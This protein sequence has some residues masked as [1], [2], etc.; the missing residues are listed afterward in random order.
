MKIKILGVLFLLLVSTMVVPAI[1]INVKETTQM[2][3][4]E[5]ILYGNN[6]NITNLPIL[7]NW[8]LDQEQTD[9]CGHGIILATPWLY[10]QSFTPTEDKIT[11]VRL[12]IFKYGNP[13]EPVQ[14]TVSIRD[15]LTSSD[16]TS[17]TIDTSVVTIG[18]KAIWVLFDFKDISVIPGSKYFIVCSGNAGDDTNA[19]CWFYE[20]GVPP[21]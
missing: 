10:A 17:K 5:T 19:Y 9:N 18:S 13:P 14:I 8:G 2:K 1:N 20:I 3:V 6:K 12:F 16:L 15:N 7:L 11:A 4:F 21:L